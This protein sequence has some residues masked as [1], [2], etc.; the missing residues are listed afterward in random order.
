[1]FLYK[2]PSTFRTH[3]NHNI[4]RSFNERN[5]TP[6]DSQPS[7]FPA[8]DPFRYVTWRNF[9]RNRISCTG[10]IELTYLCKAAS[11]KAVRRT[12]F[13]RWHR[14]GCRIETWFHGCHC[15]V[16]KELLWPLLTTGRC[17]L[18]RPPYTTR[19]RAMSSRSSLPFGL[20]TISPDI[21]G[22]ARLR[23]AQSA[24]S[25]VSSDGP[26]TQRVAGL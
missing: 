1:M 11:R 16:F 8:P 3:P 26:S 18:R 24:S 7:S 14:G 25:T 4:V 12:C 15:D 21:A 5:G 9:L 22:M 6:S 2:S 17:E 19:L 20:S 13:T 23:C 10:Y